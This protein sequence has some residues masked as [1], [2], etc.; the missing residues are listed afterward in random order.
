METV[1]EA[2]DR[3]GSAFEKGRREARRLADDAKQAARSATP[4]SDDTDTRP[5]EERTRDEL[6]ALAA[7]REIEGRSTMRKDELIAA[8]RAER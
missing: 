6:Y 5:Y 8:L 3:A 4:G 1:D 2:V 7:D